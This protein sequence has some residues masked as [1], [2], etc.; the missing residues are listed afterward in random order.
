MYCFYDVSLMLEEWEEAGRELLFPL[1]YSSLLC[2][3]LLNSH[4][5]TE[6]IVC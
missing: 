3:R 5:F 4:S 1:L 2:A 6:T